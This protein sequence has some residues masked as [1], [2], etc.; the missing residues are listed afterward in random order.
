[1]CVLYIPPWV[2]IFSEMMFF[3]SASK[4]CSHILIPSLF[5]TEKTEQVFSGRHGSLPSGV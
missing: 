1:M 3:V 5:V 4:K 2:T